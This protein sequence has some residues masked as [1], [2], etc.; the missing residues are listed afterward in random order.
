MDCPKC[1]G[2]MWVAV[3]GESTWF[4]CI[5]GKLV[6]IEIVSGGIRRVYHTPVSEATL[7]RRGSK[8]S[9]CLG[10]MAGRGSMETSVLA[11][12]L[13]QSTSETASQLSVL[14]S[15]GL[16]D[17]ESSRKGIVGGSSWS[18]TIEAKQLYK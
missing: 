15:K 11:K 5:C 13:D 18:L 9:L 12:M 7:P 2:N 14:Q 3:M 8:L 1:S 17:K 16:V 4:K 10:L 6:P